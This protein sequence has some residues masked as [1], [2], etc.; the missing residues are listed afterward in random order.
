MFPGPGGFPANGGP[1]GGAGYGAAGYAAPGYGPPRFDHPYPGTSGAQFEGAQ[2]EGAPGAA[3]PGFPGPA[4]Y[5]PPPGQ[6]FRGQQAVPPGYAHDMGQEP[7]QQAPGWRGA[8][9]F[10]SQGE[11]RG[12]GGQPYPGGPGPGLAGP[13]SAGYAPPGYPGPGA[14]PGP[15]GFPP[16]HGYPGPAGQAGA[17]GGQNAF[18]GQAGYPMAGGFAGP[19][20]AQAPYAEYRA[21]HPHGA[22]GAYPGA[23]GYGEI[24]NGGDYAYV[25]RED[26]PAAPQFRARAG[27]RGQ[28]LGG[29]SPA[30]AGSA[31]GHG[32]SS[33]GPART[34]TSA[35]AGASAGSA[36]GGRVRAITS[37]A[38]SAGW[39]ASADR[40]MPTANPGGLPPVPRSSAPAGATGPAGATIPAG[41]AATTGAAT[42]ASARPKPEAAPDV[43]PALAYGPDDPAYGPP[44]P[45]WYRQDEERAPRTKDGGSPAAA[46]EPRA[47]RGPFE[48]LRPGDREEA[49]YADY[50]PADGDAAFD[51]LDVEPL[52]SE[53]SEYGPI[54]DEM[55][56]L[57]D[58]GTPTDPEAG[59]LGQIRDLYQTAETASQASVDRH[60][61]QLLERQRELISEYFE[62]AGALGP[63]EDVTPAAPVALAG[64]SAPLGFD[65]A[66]SLAGLRSDLRGA[67]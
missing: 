18:P 28:G 31:S 33:G 55:S 4:G 56:E 66:E 34:G 38:V 22:P 52:E 9:G 29:W 16:G 2:F 62:E 30:D 20:E 37:G 43:D 48:P 15:A 45:D 12:P 50:Q 24:V 3:P 61:D 59:A 11:V 23:A 25:I 32:A 64:P 39:P 21:W 44:G 26:D 51:D 60:F 67:Q 35:G 41:S 17:Q 40:P 46:G 13:G 58:F 42:S 7:R 14:F 5:G 47:A 8:D 10:P 1:G 36:Q 65:T 57:F 6:Q 19:G 53:I 27:E 63:A 49:G 54:D